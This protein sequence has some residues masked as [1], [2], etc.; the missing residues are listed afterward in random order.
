MI[1]EA[2]LYAEVDKEQL[3]EGANLMLELAKG[4]MAAQHTRHGGNLQ[5]TDGEPQDPEEDAV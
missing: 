1:Y 3:V 5:L 2:G 4:L